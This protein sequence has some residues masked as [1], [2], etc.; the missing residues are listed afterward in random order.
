MEHPHVCVE[1]SILRAEVLVD[2]VV[3]RSWARVI[4]LS[5][6][7][8]YSYQGRCILLHQGYYEKCLTKWVYIRFVL[9]FAWNLDLIAGTV[10][11]HRKVLLSQ[12]GM[13]LHRPIH[14]AGAHHGHLQ[15]HFS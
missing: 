15:L 13:R 10:R 9:R 3:G 1:G 11:T 6:Q 5:Y 2:C 7:L 8:R 12:H 4:G 14:V